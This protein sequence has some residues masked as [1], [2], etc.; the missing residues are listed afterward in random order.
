MEAQSGQA[1]AIKL[2][3]FQLRV[4]LKRFGQYTSTRVTHVIATET[5]NLFLIK[6][7]WKYKG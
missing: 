3:Y 5:G 7:S 6:F 4:D 1:V 2:K